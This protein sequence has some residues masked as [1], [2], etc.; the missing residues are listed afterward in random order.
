MDKNFHSEESL[1]PFKTLD[2]ETLLREI[3]QLAME[4]I[5]HRESAGAELEKTFYAL[6][7]AKKAG[8][9][10]REEAELFSALEQ[11]KQGLIHSV[12]ALK[13]I[14][15]GART[16]RWVCEKTLQRHFDSEP[17]LGGSIEGA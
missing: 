7:Q 12:E 10:A 11:L 14:E 5:H 17:P 9:I 2:D 6:E 15:A 4:V 13:E 1:P 8:F 16:A 3:I